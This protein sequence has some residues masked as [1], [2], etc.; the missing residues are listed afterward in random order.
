MNEYYATILFKKKKTG[1]IYQS[2]NK[3]K[4]MKNTFYSRQTI[5]P[6]DRQVPTLPLL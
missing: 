5:K 2:P 3:K 4:I 1:S 6:T